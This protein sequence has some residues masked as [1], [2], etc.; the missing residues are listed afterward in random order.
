MN[1]RTALATGLVGAIGFALGG[2]ATR[3]PRAASVPA[4]PRVRLTPLRVAPELVIR[5]TVGLRPHRPG[6]FVLRAEKLDDRLLVHNYGHGGAGWSLSWGTGSMAA[7][8]VGEAGHRQAAVIGCGIVGITCA[9]L[10]Q[11]RGIETTIFTAAVPPETTSN[12]AEAMF[13]PMA[14]LSNA[15]VRTREWEAQ[16]RQAVEIAYR[17]W[18][19]RASASG[20]VSWVD[21]YAVT[22]DPGSGGETSILP[23]SVERAQT[24]LGPGEHPFPSSYAVHERNLRFEP[25]MVLDEL[26]RDFMLFGGRLELRRF[27]SRSELTALSQSAIVNCTGLGARDLLGDT[28]L[29]PVKG[30]LH[31]LAPQAG[32]D[33]ATFGGPRPAAG[34][35]GGLLYMM[36][37]QDGI[38]LGGSS[39]RGVSTLEPN[40]DERQRILTSHAELFGSMRAG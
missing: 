30:Q 33:Y 2:C 38:V 40:E 9:R 27:A 24:V 31:V 15:S 20:G 25:S 13:T 14:G 4:R 35:T 10:L 7:D 6:G 36:P 29:V 17:E 19:F 3:A 11:R 34:A 8:I 28:D 32:V 22:D 21:H 16:F 18:Q 39:E 5:T 26:L 12:M 37:R 1:R 23:A